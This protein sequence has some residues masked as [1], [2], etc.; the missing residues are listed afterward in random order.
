MF[1][2]TRW[3]H[4]S[5]VQDAEA[6]E[7]SVPELAAQCGEDPT[8]MWVLVEGERVVGC[9]SV[10]PE[11][12]PTGWTE[13]ERSE[14]AVFLAT[15]VTDPAYRAHCPG[16]LIALWALDHAARSG[17]MW[18]RRG[19]TEQPLVDYYRDVQGWRLMH[20]EPVGERIVHMLGR[21]AELVEH[22]PQLMAGR[23]L[24]R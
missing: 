19:T 3:M 13:A 1:A 17:A 7:S 22:L 6:W 16:W 20:S 23:T 10:Y 14:S 24:A 18:V 8:F 2:R 21:R 9:T 5:G 11:T 12:P 4:R 15:T